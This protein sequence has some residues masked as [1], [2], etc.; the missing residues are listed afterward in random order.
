MR[1]IAVLVILGLTAA[2]LVSNPATFAAAERCFGKQAT[3]ADHHGDVEGTPGNDRICGG[4][5]DVGYRFDPVAHASGGPGADWLIGG[6]NGGNELHGGP[7]ADHRTGHDGLD[8]LIGGAGQ[9]HI[10]GDKGDDD[11]YGDTGNDH[12]IGES[13]RDKL[14]GGADLDHVSGGGAD[15]CYPN[16]VYEDFFPC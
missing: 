15:K 11:L 4:D 10:H 12:L 1:R 7:G 3:I 9:D 16:K 6:G 8:L 13:G 14:V 2:P 5:D